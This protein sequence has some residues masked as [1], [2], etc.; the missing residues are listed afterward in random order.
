MLPGAGRLGDDSRRGG[1]DGG[2]AKG[3]EL[4]VAGDLN[5]E[6]KNSS[7]QGGYEDIMV[8]VATT[9]L[10]DITGDLFLQRR[11]WCKD[12]R[13]WAVV[14]KGRVVRSWTDYILGSDCRIFQNVSVRDPRHTSDQFMV[15]GCLCGA[16]PR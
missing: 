10:E 5:V 15:V 16:F 13:T 9:G 14:R 7:G 11:E 1:G 6:L 3:A 8:A 2:A 12:R 4:I